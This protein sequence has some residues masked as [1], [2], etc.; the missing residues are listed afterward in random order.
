[1]V[2]YTLEKAVL[3]DSLVLDAGIAVAHNDSVGAV[4]PDS[5]DDFLG[6]KD[7]LVVDAGTG[8]TVPGSDYSKRDATWID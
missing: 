2:D 1:M 5:V 4:V 8:Y 7:S 3:P 6:H